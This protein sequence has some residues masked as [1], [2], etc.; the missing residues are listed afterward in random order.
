MRYIT[1]EPGV[2]AA[3]I[4]LVETVLARVASVQPPGIHITR[5]DGWFGERWIGFS[6]KAMGAFGVHHLEEMNIPPFVPSR[7]ITSSYLKLVGGGY[8]PS[9]SPLQLHIHQRSEANFRRKVR[10]LVPSD[11]M[12]WFSGGSESDGRGSILAYV[13][14]PQGHS[15]WFVSAVRDPS[16]RII[17]SIGLSSS[18]LV[19][20]NSA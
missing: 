16:W 14:S 4:A 20:T 19:A 18:E 8:E 12:I 13:P 7:V 2:D 9:E 1:T 11:A 15:P 10:E 17:K 6:G 5:I 3:F